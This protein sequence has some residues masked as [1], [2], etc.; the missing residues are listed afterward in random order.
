MCRTPHLHAAG[1]APPRW[2]S[3]LLRRGVDWHTGGGLTSPGTRWRRWR[4]WIPLSTPMGSGTYW[5]LSWSRMRVCSR[6]LNPCVWWNMS[7]VWTWMVCWEDTTLRAGWLNSCRWAPSSSCEY[8]KRATEVELIFSNIL[9]RYL[10][11]LQTLLK[12]IY[13]YLFSR[14]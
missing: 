14:Y 7:I 6:S 2:T 4:G 3:G 5:S 11:G 9:E 13:R 1:C 8:T 12:D 10:V